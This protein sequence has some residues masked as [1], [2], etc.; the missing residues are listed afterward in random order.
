VEK[1]RVCRVAIEAQGCCKCDLKSTIKVGQAGL[2]KSYLAG[3]LKDE[4]KKLITT[5][6]W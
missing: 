6:T 5:K 1:G 3:K 2:M 4:L